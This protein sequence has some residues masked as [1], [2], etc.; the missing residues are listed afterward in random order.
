VENMVRLP[1]VFTLAA[2]IATYA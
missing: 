2:V 1:D